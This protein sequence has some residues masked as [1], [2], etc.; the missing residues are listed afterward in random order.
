MK[1]IKDL[2]GRRFGLLTVISYVPGTKTTRAGW[3]CRCDCGEMRTNVEVEAPLTA[4]RKVKNGT[5]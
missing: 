1:P 2:A 5:D 4:P 3:L